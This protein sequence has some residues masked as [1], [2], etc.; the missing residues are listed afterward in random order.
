M[1]S[2]TYGVATESSRNGKGDDTLTPLLISEETH[3]HSDY[4]AHTEHGINGKDPPCLDSVHKSRQKTRH[5]CEEGYLS[6][7]VCPV[8]DFGSVIHLAGA[9]ETRSV[10]IAAIQ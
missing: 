1:E 4:M 8:Q 6:V 7:C 3:K 10:P 5:L 9:L 2:M